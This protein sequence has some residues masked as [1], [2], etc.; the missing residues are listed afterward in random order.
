MMAII[1]IR[2]VQLYTWSVS[3]SE[4]C[5][6]GNTKTRLHSHSPAMSQTGTENRLID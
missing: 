5:K 4:I 6:R 2:K 3:T 1:Y